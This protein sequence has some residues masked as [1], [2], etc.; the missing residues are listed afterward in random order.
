MSL[1]LPLA[2]WG[3]LAIPCL[4]AIYL[5]RR[6]LKTRMTSAL[7]LWESPGFSLSSGR[8]ISRLESSLLLLLE[9]LMVSLLVIAASAPG[10]FRKKGLTTLTV[11]LDD[12]ASMAATSPGRPSPRDKAAEFMLKHLEDNSPFLCTLVLSGNSPAVLSSSSSN[13]RDIREALKLWKPAKPF[14]DPAPGIR[15]ARQISGESSNVLFLTDHPPEAD[16]KN[17]PS[18]PSDVLWHAFGTRQDNAAFTF[19]SRNYDPVDAS[20]ELFLVLAN[21]AP[22]PADL[23]LIVSRGGTKLLSRKINIGSR[24]TEKIAISPAIPCADDVL[25]VE[26]S[27]RGPLG[28]DT[29]LLLAPEKQLPLRVMTRFKDNKPLDDLFNFTLSSMGGSISRVEERPELLISDD[30]EFILS[31]A[32]LFPNSWALQVNPLNEEPKQKGKETS[33]RVI[34]GPYSVAKDHPLCENLSLSGIRWA[35]HVNTEKQ[36]HILPLVGA[37]DHI[38]LGEIPAASD[39]SPQ[40]FVL[41]FVPERSNLQKTP[42]WPVLLHNLV[43]TVKNSREGFSTRNII[44]GV[45]AVMNMPRSPLPLTGTSREETP[46]S[47]SFVSSGSDTKE[48]RETFMARS[49]RWLFI[50]DSNGLF[51]VSVPE[52]NTQLLSANFISP[53]ESD[54]KGAATGSWGH[55][56]ASQAIAL[57][58][59]RDEAWLFILATIAVAISHMALVSRRETLA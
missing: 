49:H 23:E 10:C 33:L 27:P 19:A 14:H 40:H 31:S 39:C 29:R 51:E 15:L 3:M 1:A 13:L 38:L 12:S 55:K 18:T 7:F 4:I 9:L 43:R 42:A 25:S 32:M 54:L 48:S 2:L 28:L 53:D 21:F 17:V 6:K 44:V 30:R 22:K 50:P 46:V 57:P 56:T 45:P 59:W 34:K 58:S 47:V 8:K 24:A 5:F 41:N 11:L 20:E 26:L 36:D 35:M 37:G 52:G 16:S